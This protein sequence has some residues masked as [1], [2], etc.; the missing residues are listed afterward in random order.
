M[1]SDNILMIF[2]KNPE[3]GKV[4]TRLASTIGKEKALK[5]YKTL[6]AHTCTIVN[7]ISFDKAVFYSDSITHNDLWDN[8]MFQKYLQEGE[9]LGEKMLSA[10]T[11]TFAI[12]YK[13][14]VIIGSDC[15][16]LTVKIIEEAFELLRSND[17]VIGPA[18]DGGYYLLGMNKLYKELFQ[19]KKWSSE[20]VL[21]DTVI[22]LKKI[23][24]PYKLLKT[25]SDV[26][27]EEDLGELKKLIGKTEQ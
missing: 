25:L 12:G 9:D 10:F 27:R 18:K 13:N 17:V 5:V 24:V 22:D 15:I 3:L 8:E 19:N 21:L 6:L 26:D 1:N 7:S 14:V 23:N 11:F 4:K 16:E 20:N 2:V